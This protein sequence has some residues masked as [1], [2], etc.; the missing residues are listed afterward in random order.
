MK[1]GNLF[2]CS[3]IVG[4]L[5]VVSG[6]AASA[7]SC[8]AAKRA[9]V[10]AP[11]TPQKS[12]VSLDCSLALNRRDIVTKRILI[13]GQEGSGISVNCG[14]ALLDGRKGK[15]NFGRDMIVLKSRKT[16]KGWQQLHDVKI[17]NCRINGSIRIYGL[18]PNGENKQ[19]RASSHQAGHTARAQKIA[20]TRISL[21][22]L[23]IKG[24]GRIPV[25][26]SPGATRVTLSHSVLAGRSSSVAIY[27]DA[28]SGYNKIERNQ[29]RVKTRRRELI[30]IDGSAHNNINGN[31]FYALRNGGIYLYRNCGEGG[32]VRHQAPQNN[33]I[34][35]NGFF[36]KKFRGFTRSLRSFGQKKAV[37]AIWVGSRNGGRP[38]CKRDKGYSFGSS[39]NDGDLATGN[40]IVGNQFT[41]VSPNRVIKVFSKANTLSGNEKVKKIRLR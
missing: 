5:L 36:Y 1:F 19:V 13:E 32:T 11:A 23:F 31:M 39:V 8:S 7:K 30:A 9:E 33:V 6:S 10:L 3:I 37:P 2:L 26:I 18:G 25:Y 27:L 20:P 16:P 14:G 17:T 12:F 35:N 22:R 21:S 41:K 34:I 24:Q 4:T 40:S 29:F 38:Y 28:E 15:P